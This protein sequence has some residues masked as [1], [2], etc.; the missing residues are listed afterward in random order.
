M[1][2]MSGCC[3]CTCMLEIP[4]QRV[5]QLHDERRQ[6]WATGKAQ[7]VDDV[8]RKITRR[9]EAIDGAVVVVV[10]MAFGADGS[11]SVEIRVPD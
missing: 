2:L 1:R 4:S 6:A 5:G 8:G 7:V 10:V 3:A 9:A 11:S